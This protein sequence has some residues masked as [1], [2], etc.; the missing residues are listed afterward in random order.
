MLDPDP[1]AALKKDVML[2]RIKTLPWAN[3]AA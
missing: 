1:D 3:N 2:I